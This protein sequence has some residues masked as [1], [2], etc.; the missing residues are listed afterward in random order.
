MSFLETVKFNEANTAA[1]LPIVGGRFAH[2]SVPLGLTCVNRQFYDKKRN[3]EIS[4]VICESEFNRLEERVQ[5]KNTTRS[6]RPPAESKKTTKKKHI[7]L[8]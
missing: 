6:S 7:K 2:L 1:G 4:E 3:I 8:N 5:Q